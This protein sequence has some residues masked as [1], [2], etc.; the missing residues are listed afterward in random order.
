[1][2]TAVGSN[3]TVPPEPTPTEAVLLAPDGLK[4]YR[5]LRPPRPPGQAVSSTWRL[6]PT[7]AQAVTWPVGTSLMGEMS[8]VVLLAHVARGWARPGGA[9]YKTKVMIKGYGIKLQ[10]KLCV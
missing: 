9:V 3:R 2:G 5:P 10:R 6:L 1:V 4:P 8:S 7:S